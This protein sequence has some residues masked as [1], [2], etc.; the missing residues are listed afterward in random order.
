MIWLGI[1]GYLD[2]AETEKIPQ[3]A[4]VFMN[5]LRKQAKK[6]LETIAKQRILEKETEEILKTEAAEAKKLSE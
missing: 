4:E 6:P 3:I 1:S 5:L 2:D